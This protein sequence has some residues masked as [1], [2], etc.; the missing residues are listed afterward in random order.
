MRDDLLSKERFDYSSLSLSLSLK[1][2]SEENEPL[3]LKSRELVAGSVRTDPTEVL[4]ARLAWNS[5]QSVDVYN[6]KSVLW[7][8]DKWRTILSLS[9]NLAPFSKK[10]EREKKKFCVFWANER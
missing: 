9:G 8:N 2:D 3:W 10:K 4:M 7:D 1:N 5:Y 6:V